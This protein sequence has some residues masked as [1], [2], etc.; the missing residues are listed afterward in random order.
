MAKDTNIEWTDHTFNPWWGCTKISP[1]C[2]NCYAETWA[3][4]YGHDVWGTRKGRRT[5][6]ARH[7]HQPIIWNLRA[8]REDKRIRVF[9]AS[10]ADVFEENPLVEEERQRLWRL[11]VQTPYLDWLLLTKRPENMRKFVPWGDSWPSNVW[12]MTSVENQQQANFRVPLL[13]KVPAV[14]RA[15]S[16]E[17]MLGPVDLSRWIETID[18][19]IVGGESGPKSRPMQPSWVKQ[20]RDLCV[21]HNVP[22]FFKQWGN[23]APSANLDFDQIASIKHKTSDSVN[24]K[25]ARMAKKVAGRKLDGEIWNEF[26]RTS[27]TSHHV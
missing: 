12:A 23:W 6:G 8:K 18:W 9:C 25:M 7:W 5:F 4:R 21:S 27:R 14:V 26:P 24:V 22:F 13:A 19:V 16:V 17:P 3:R 1:G 15:L 11:I 20:V 2:T 10:M